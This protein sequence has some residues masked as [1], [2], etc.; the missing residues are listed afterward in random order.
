MFSI[1][2]YYCLAFSWNENRCGREKREATNSHCNNLADQLRYAEDVRAQTL[3]GLKNGA[4]CPLIDL[5]VQGEGNL[6]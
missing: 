4:L 2:K 3:F 5:G 1:G 6:R